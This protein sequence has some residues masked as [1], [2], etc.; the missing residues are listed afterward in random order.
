M[1]VTAPEPEPEPN[2]K[3]NP[4]LT[5]DTAPEWFAVEERPPSSN[6]NTGVPDIEMDLR[7]MLSQVRVRVMARVRVRVFF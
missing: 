7:I 3:P 6:V 2:S 4:H 1:L 5:L